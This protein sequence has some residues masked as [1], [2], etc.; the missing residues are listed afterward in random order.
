MYDQNGHQQTYSYVFSAW[1]IYTKTTDA[2]I[3]PD[4]VAGSYGLNGYVL[5]TNPGTAFEN[6]RTTSD[7]WRTPNVQGANNVPLLIEASRFDLWPVATDPP[8]LLED[9]VWQ[10]N[11]HMARACLNRHNGFVN[12]LFC[13]F[14]VRKVGVKELWTLKWHKRFN[15]INGAWTKSGGAIASDWPD[16]MRRFKDY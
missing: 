15:N 1:G 5:S 2:R 3:C 9:Q 11:N 10:S 6:G 13:D 14:T 8:P 12:S 7:N 16:W 4:G